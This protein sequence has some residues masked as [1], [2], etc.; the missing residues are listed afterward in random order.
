MTLGYALGMPKVKKYFWHKVG[1]SGACGR[2]AEGKSLVINYCAAQV[3]VVKN[4]CSTG[5]AGLLRLLQVELALEFCYS[6]CL[7]VRM[8][9]VSGLLED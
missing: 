4:L 6:L 9:P 7:G 5:L 1:G 2:P 8:L 3:P